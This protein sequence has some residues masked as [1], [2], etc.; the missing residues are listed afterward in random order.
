MNNLHTQLKA[1][2]KELDEFGERYHQ[3]K[4]DQ[5]FVAWFIRAY[6]TP[7]EK[8]AVE[9]VG[10]ASGDKG[11]DG[12]LIAERAK[13][14]FVIQAKYRTARRGKAEPRAHIMQFASLAEEITQPNNDDFRAFIKKMDPAT[15]EQLKEV[16][17]RVNRHA[18][19]LNLL[20]V[21]LGTCSKTVEGDARR[22]VKRANRDAT[23][24]IL[25]GQRV[26]ILLKDYL[27]GAAPPIPLLDLPL[28]S[29]P[30]VKVNGVLQRYDKAN[31]LES[32]VF[33]MGG[34]HI[35]DL[36]EIAG[37]RIFARNIRGFLGESTPINRGMTK[38][39][40]DEPNH[41]FYY[42][43]GVTIV[44]DRAEK[45]SHKGVDILRVS[46]PQ[47][48]NGQQTSRMLAEDPKLSGKASVLVKVIQIPREDHAQDGT[49]DALISRIVQATNWQNA[50]KP[51]DLMANDRKQIEI[52]KGLRH[53]DIFYLRK[54]QT[55]LEARR[56]MG[57]RRY[58]PL[59][60]EELALAIAGCEL[61][62]VI[63]RS[64]KDNLFTEEHYDSVFPNTNPAFYLP[65]LLLSREVTSWGRGKPQRGYAK[66]LVLGFVWKR[67]GPFVRSTAKVERFRQL[68]LREDRSLMSPLGRVINETYVGAL[69]YY[70]ANKGAGAEEV[71]LFFRSKRGRD[72]EFE[73]FWKT[74]PA[75][76]RRRWDDWLVA[77]RKALEG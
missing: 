38:T 49:F 44:C 63:A 68:V 7:D 29:S 15:A 21:T 2:D 73:D 72:R 8:H 54:R 34:D 3:L 66:W 5:L 6:L 45:I 46:N 31:R 22:Q 62:P 61:D 76:R 42:N 14:A 25:S 32:W 12:V 57:N 56:L 36:F 17:Q 16:R 71:S 23:I 10:G 26:V 39:L 53:Y 1:L 70:R 77:C 65:R 20:Y 43:N 35:A 52:E 4:K 11:I 47:I 33:T 74:L 64:G 13:A 58:S 41:F 40:R 55:K 59:S 50:I 37:P 69:K 9:C 18:F 19:R 67:L 75:K 24:E 60:K 30:T 27:D 28:E 51:S 48:I